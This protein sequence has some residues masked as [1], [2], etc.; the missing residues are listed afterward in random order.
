MSK[1]IVFSRREVWSETKEETGD[2]KSVTLHRSRNY[3]GVVRVNATEERTRPAECNV[4]H[5][6]RSWIL[7]LCIARF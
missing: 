5:G 3:G 1:A 2:P 4:P 6:V 7:S